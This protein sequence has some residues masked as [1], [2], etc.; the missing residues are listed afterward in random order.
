MSDKDCMN[1]TRYIGLLGDLTYETQTFGKNT[2]HYKEKLNDLDS[3]MESFANKDAQIEKEHNLKLLL[4]VS[5]FMCD[6]PV[7]EDICYNTLRK[8]VKYILRVDKR[9]RSESDLYTNL[10]IRPD[11]LFKQWRKGEIDDYY[12]LKFLLEWRMKI[13]EVLGDPR[14]LIVADC[15]TACVVKEIDTR[16]MNTA[17]KVI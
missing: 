15:A 5:R 10:N 12:M 9:R 2:Q 17:K 11:L 14:Y 6:K 1:L 8:I 13:Q 16:F 3:W 7:K 4:N